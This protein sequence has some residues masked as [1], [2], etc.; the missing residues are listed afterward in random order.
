MEDNSNNIAAK[1]V[2]TTSAV[3]TESLGEKVGRNLKGGE[4]IVLSSD[5]GGGKTTFVRGLARGADSA[6]HVSSPTFT[7]S[8]VYQLQNDTKASTDSNTKTLREIQH[9]DFYRLDE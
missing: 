9:F 5:L 6:D 1:T 2:V 4:V 8:K 7:L 3:E